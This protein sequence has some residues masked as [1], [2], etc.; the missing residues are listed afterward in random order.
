MRDIVI[1]RGRKWGQER[2]RVREDKG[3]EGNLFS[4]TEGVIDREIK[5]NGR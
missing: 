1:G 5:G 2:E 3:R 4:G